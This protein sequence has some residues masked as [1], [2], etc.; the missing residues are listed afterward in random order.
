MPVA[1]DFSIV[2]VLSSFAVQLLVAIGCI[3]GFS[4]LRPTNK[5]VYQPKLK[6]ASDENRPPPL[7]SYPTAWIVPIMKEDSSKAVGQ[8]GIDSALF[9][10]FVKY[11]FLF[12]CSLTLLAIP[13][14]AI[15]AN[16]EHISGYVANTGA[17]TNVTN[18]TLSSRDIDNSNLTA[19]F[20]SN[21]NILSIKQLDVTS[22][23][24]WM[25][26]GL[27]WVF[28]I[29]AYILLFRL[30]GVYNAYRK[31]FFK[32]GKFQN[33]L[34]NRT[35][36]VTNLGESLRSD[37]A[38]SNYMSS[39]SNLAAP[40][41]SIVNRNVPHLTKMVAEHEKLTLQLEKVLSKYLA[42]PANIP[43]KR[44]TLDIG[45]DPIR[46]LTGSVDAITF[47]G[48]SINALEEKIYFIRAQPDHEHP[49]NSAGFVSYGNVLDAHEAAQAFTGVSTS[50]SVVATLNAK[51][52]P[53][54]D[55][56]L[57][58]NIGMAPAERY[59][60]RMLALGLTVG[61]SIGWILLAGLIAS[62][63]NLNSVFSSNQVVL[64]WLAAN[65]EPKALLQS[66]AAPI[67]LAVLNYLLPIVLRIT[68]ILQGAKSNAGVERS[69]LYKLFTFYMIQ[70]FLFAAVSAI[71]AA[72]KQPSTDG[73][74]ITDE[75]KWRVTGAIS[76]LTNNSNFYIALLSTYYAGYGIE[77]IQGLPL[78]MNFIKRK[79][80]KLTPRQNFELNKPP[81]FDF[82]RIYGTLMTAF[83]IALTFSVVAPII[84]PFGAL[85]FGL[86]FVVMKY[87]LM[88]VYTVKGETHGSYFLKVF[89]LLLFSMGF[90]QLLTLTVIFAANSSDTKTTST[91]RQWM[92]VAPLPFLTAALWIGSRLWLLPR[93]VFCTSTLTHTTLLPQDPNATH[94]ADRVLNPALAKPLMKVWVPKKSADLLPGLYTPRYASMDAYEA[95]HPE[96]SQGGHAAQKNRRAWMKGLPSLAGKRKQIAQM[97]ALAEEQKGR[98]AGDDEGM[99]DGE[100]IALKLVSGRGMEEGRA[101]STELLLEGN[102]SGE[103]LLPPEEV[104]ALRLQIQE[105]ARSRAPRGPPANAP[106]Q[107]NMFGRAFRSQ[108]RPEL[109]QP[110]PS[111]Q[112]I[113]P[114][115]HRSR[116]RN[117]SKR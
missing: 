78:V 72:Y 37:S 23:W 52:A 39:R 16:F 26:T 94:L 73:M 60:R 88:Y 11:V 112:P 61:I 19:I 21:L 74:S 2:G 97:Q 107:G 40:T 93:A 54:F 90:F 1:A 25:P 22:P 15:N 115:R 80:F 24:Y 44:P 28:S 92:I 6:F 95:A 50:K 81:T 48:D 59:S 47:L 8:L 63:S 83:T 30:Y 109:Q 32:S 43:A 103:D 42:D 82:T 65:P 98:V 38:L 87:Q 29:L 89:N 18:G 113:P 69:V 57:W 58:E 4:L 99:E 101:G 51:L 9:I 66:Y 12:F 71:I 76:G 20:Q 111:G 64:D 114:P 7:A 117:D 85:F 77:I 3:V 91:L 102:G 17:A 49:V 105:E 55:D 41:Q 68:T 10:H 46:G 75:F 104:E 5:I 70:I 62:L 45:S 33:N 96:L 13:Y 108:V 79:F 14:M 116:T 36:L 106:A 84:L 100:A 110:Q 67:L 35:L 34:H 31:D 56:I 53:K 27:A 86:V